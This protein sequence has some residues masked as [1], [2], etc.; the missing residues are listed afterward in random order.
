MITGLSI[1]AMASMAFVLMY[2]RWHSQESKTDDDLDLK[3]S[4]MA[5]EDA[6]EEA[7]NEEKTTD[8]MTTLLPA[9]T[10]FQLLAKIGEGSYGK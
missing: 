8:G 5:G 1:V 6:A 3:E 10:T 7:Q 9:T 4:L 2:L